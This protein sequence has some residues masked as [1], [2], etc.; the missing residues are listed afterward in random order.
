MLDLSKMLKGY[1]TMIFNV[2][3]SLAMILS[4]TGVIAPEQVPGQ[5]AV[6]TFLD[7]LSVVLGGVTVV[8]N[9]ILRAV[10]NT[11]LGRK[12]PAAPVAEP[13]SS[14]RGA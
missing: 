12:E 8:I 6:N 4:A 13:K 7:N 2:T 14:R 3:M 11:P 10:T 5:E 9:M 1:R